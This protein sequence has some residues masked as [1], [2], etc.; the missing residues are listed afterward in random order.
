[1]NGRLF[2]RVKIKSKSN[3]KDGGLPKIADHC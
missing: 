3:Q 1:M 2:E